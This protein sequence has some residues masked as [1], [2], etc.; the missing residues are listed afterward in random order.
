[1]G[2]T[3]GGVVCPNNPY[4]WM[5]FRVFVRLLIL[6]F[7]KK[8]VCLR[9]LLPLSLGAS[10]LIGGGIE[11]QAVTTKQG[12]SEVVAQSKTITVKGVVVDATHNE[13]VIGAT[14]MLKEDKSKGTQTNLD[15]EFTL[16][17]VPSNGT[18][19]VSYIGMKTVTVAING[20]TTINISL[21][22]DNELLQEV[23]VTGYGGKQS[24]VKVT[25]SIA[26]VDTE[27]LT[28]GVY[29]NPA[30]ALS[31]AISGLRV[32]QSSGNP[33]AT[34]QIILRGGTNFNGSGSPLVL[35]DGQLRGSL[36]DI[37]P[38]DIES[39]SMLKDA[40]A[41][42]LY[43][44]RAANG[45]ILV[46]TK[47]GKAGMGE[48]NVK[49]RVGLNYAVFPHKFL[50][51]KDYITW[52]RRAYDITPWAPKNNLNGAQPMGIGNVYGPGM[53]WNLM[54]YNPKYDELLAKGWQKMKDPL[55]D[56][57]LMYKETFPQDYNFVNPSMT[58]DYNVSLSGGNDKGTYY[59]GLGYNHSQGLPVTSFYKR[60]SFVLNGSYNI[61]PWLTSRSSFN[62][63][64]ANWNSMPGSQGS[65]ENYFGRINS[66]PTTARYT[67]EDGNPLLGPNTGDGNQM[68]QPQKWIRDN[69]TDKFTMIQAF[70]VK[71]TD[72]LKL[73]LTGN[74]YYSEGFY[75]GFNKDR[76]TNQE[77]TSWQRGRETWAKF[78]RGLA[79]TYNGVFNF[80]K[81]FGQHSV[82]VMLGM[83]YFQDA[84]K[85]FSAEGS[86]APTDD[87]MD[88]GLTLTEEGKRKIDS[89]H[90]KYRILSYFGRLNYEFAG[91]YLVSA[92]FREDGYSSL[93]DNRWGFFPGVS[94]GWIFG[95]ED[96]VKEAL[97]WLSFGK[98]RVSYG[99]NG[100]ASGI[101]AYTLQGSYNSA[102]YNGNTGFLIGTLPNPT[103]R[104]EK[105][106]TFEVGAD[107]SFFANRLNTNITFYDR[108][109]LDKY[110]AF[111]LPPTGGFS[112]IQNNNGKFRNRG[113]EL[114]ISGTPIKTQD[115]TW[116]IGGNITYNKN[117]IIQLPDNGLDRNRQGGQQ[118][119][120]G[121]GD[122]LQ[123]V[124]GYQEGQEP[125]VVVGYK[126]MGIFQSEEEIN[127][128]YPGGTVE[129]N[130]QG[131]KSYTPA[132]WAKL[133]DAQRKNAI[134]LTP[135]DMR[136]KD[137]NGDGKIDSFDQVVF[138]N[139]MPHWT[140][141]LTST[142]SWKGLR[143]YLAVDYALGFW[144]YDN[145]TPWYIGAAQGTYNTID[146][147]FNTWTPENRNAKYPKY[148]YADMLGAA[149]FHRNSDL[150]A[151]KGDYLAFRELSLSY[152]LPQNI[153]EM[154]AA[155]RIEFSV[156]GQNLGYLV[157]AKVATPERMRT[158]GV[159]SGTGYSLPRTVLFGLN[160]TF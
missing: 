81:Y 99:I 67:D 157:G 45:V 139:A 69:Q 143:L 133:T 129:G 39:M 135:G 145:T 5:D 132:A 114:E 90:S 29:S 55:S 21:Q 108:L 113:V 64:R 10:L 104:W 56:K 123:W 22:E 72:Y 60:Y 159:A 106:R 76:V 71:F 102:K 125:W 146:M 88:L 73:T 57:I 94:G 1:M 144:N 75:E 118:I 14:V 6:R 86:G 66:V 138:G 109:T 95:N 100:N 101:G 17:N 111:D 151:Y 112:S 4:L 15:G 23:V 149:N 107:M 48:I 120:T 47:S 49:A 150:F 124:G 41:T 65:E 122:E 33:G 91:K 130:V 83:E 126:S 77:G 58:Q 28:V 36:S 97:P 140:G 51:A 141:G 110:A 154:V 119:Y 96:F 160:V 42:A 93:L 13:P 34:P 84:S 7:M 12:V 24:R 3:E 62:F 32:V 52:M 127:A 137:I 117:T 16:A 43:G 153:S 134:L 11:T 19:E 80:S 59:A 152:T 9:A 38:N 136:W 20:R 82:D 148:V 121:K 87:F 40:G 8:I 70:D 115:F 53:K 35:V 2:L 147:V 44:A 92:V 31:G 158:G 105:T 79:Q 54:E 155:K 156:T 89:Y 98:L 116:Q 25:N 142:M 46:T 27:K 37:N 74:W 85:G 128:A 50:G 131:K 61:K 18:L 26:N 103:L 30:Q 63:N 78:D 68:F